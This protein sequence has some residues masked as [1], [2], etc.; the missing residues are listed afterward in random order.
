M[1]D[2]LH[3]N[4]KGIPV[5]PEANLSLDANGGGT[6]PSVESTNDPA[7]PQMEQTESPAPVS[8]PIKR[9]FSNIQR[10]QE[11]ENQDEEKVRH[12]IRK[13]SPLLVHYYQSVFILLIILFIASGYFILN[14]LISSFKQANLEIEATLEEKEG[15]ESYLASLNRSISAAETISPETMKRINEALP[16]EV[17]IPVLM[18][19]F[20]QFAKSNGVTMESI[21]FSPEQSSTGGLSYGGYALATVRASVAIKAPGYQTMRKYL[22]DLQKNIRLLDVES[23]SVSG[24]ANSGEMSYSLEMKTYFLQKTSSLMPPPGAMPMPG[25]AQMP[26]AP[27]NLN[28]I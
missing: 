6:A 27:V 19:T 11:D 10:K 18:K 21:N 16:K 23:I 26:S 4:E 12:V 20:L 15:V 5:T 28:D 7:G 25:A 22:D 8:V 2:F 14:P 9:D 17:E 1:T 3:P 13:E 24:D